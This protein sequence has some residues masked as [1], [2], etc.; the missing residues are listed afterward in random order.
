[1]TA[2]KEENLMQIAFGDFADAEAKILENTS[3]ITQKD[4][5]C[6]TMLHWAALN[7]KEQ[8]VEFLLKF[9]QCSVDES[10]DTGATPLILA[11]LKGSLAICKM[12]IERGANVNKSNSNGHTPVK[13]AGSKNHKE[14]LTYLL[15]C[16]G[17]PN[18]RDH[19]GETPLHRVASM[20]R[21]DCL[22]ILLTHPNVSKTISINAQ[23]NAGNTAMHLAL[24]ECDDL[25]A[26][27]MLY[28]SGASTDIQNKAEATPLEVCK[29]ATQRKLLEYIKNKS[30]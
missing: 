15:D 18:A 11:T 3:L 26:A 5:N 6:R 1:M 30:C 7:G 21:H 22:Q 17:D 20:E 9:Q 8:L 12:L 29:P 25:I 14:I 10:D 19:I 23:N 2:A 27:Q 24:G 4:S 16:N 13:Y 28:D